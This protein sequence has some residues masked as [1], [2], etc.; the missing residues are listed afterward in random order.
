MDK[1][2]SK[3]RRWIKIYP[4][5]KFIREFGHFNGLPQR[6]NEPDLEYY[7]RIWYEYWEVT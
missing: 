3:L 2:K 6:D 5:I 7:E 4:K 1:P